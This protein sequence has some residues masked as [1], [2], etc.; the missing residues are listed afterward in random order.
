MPPVRVQHGHWGALVVNNTIVGEAI[1]VTYTITIER[2]DV[3]QVGTRWTSFHEGL[4]SGEGE[5]RIHKVYSDFEGSFLPYV[6]F[7]A[8][9]LRALRNSGTPVRNPIDIQVW[10][11][12]PHGEP[13]TGQAGDVEILHNCLFWTYTGGWD[14]TALTERT[15]PFSFEGITKPALGYIPRVGA[16]NPI[17][18]Y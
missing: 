4:V 14:A 2:L 12:D 18:I 6:M 9:M 3:P 13:S 7:D 11:D 16:S 1:A 10:L 17:R 5:L 15:W 8:N